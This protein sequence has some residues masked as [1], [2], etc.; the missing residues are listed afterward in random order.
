MAGRLLSFS[1]YLGQAN[2]VQVIE[3]FPSTQKTFTYD[4][5]A[6]VSAYTF[7]ADMQ[8]LVVD[9]LTYDRTT[10]DP[11]FTDSSVVGF[12]SNSEIGAGNIVTTGASVG[13]I[14]F[15]IPAQRYTGPLLPDARA[16]VAITVVGFKWTDTDQTPTVTNSHRWAVIERYE[17]DVSPGNPRL[18][19]AF[20]ALGVGAISTFSDDSSANVSRTAGT[21]S[22]TGVTSGSSGT[23]AIFNAVV[24]SNGTIDFDITSRGTNYTVGDTITLLDSDLGGGGAPDVTI[25]VTATI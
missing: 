14:K 24:A 12:F 7:E 23:G 2:N 20:V 10:G 8:T 13:E 1:N 5:N 9:T 19:N 16:N 18:S 15:T 22:L 4:Y 3:M 6:N 17:P 25:T 11:N 21:Y